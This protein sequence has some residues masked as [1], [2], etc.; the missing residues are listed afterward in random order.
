MHERINIH[1]MF[2]NIAFEV[3]KR[4][5]CARVQVG[6]VI[7]KNQRVVSMGW[8]GVPSGK[9]HCCDIFHDKYDK[10]L[11]GTKESTKFP[12][13]KSWIERPENKA[14]HHEF[15]NVNEIHSEMN[16][17]LFAAKNGISIDRS[18]LYVTWSPCINCA[19]ALLQ[20][21]IIEVYYHYEYERDTRGIQ[22]LKENGVACHQ[23]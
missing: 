7:V 2:M 17:M 1:Q 18:S 15:A 23:I 11:D 5:T 21:G 9:T 4:S 14:E 3:S 6:A 8:N 16:A 19:K 12:D 10:Y 22:F 13:F 20:V